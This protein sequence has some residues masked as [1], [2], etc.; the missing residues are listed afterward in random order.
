M[1]TRWVTRT[2]RG[3]VSGWY[4]TGQA[5]RTRDGQGRRVAGPDGRGEWSHELPDG[6]S[7]ERVELPD[8]SHE[9]ILAVSS[10]A[11]SC[12]SGCA[13]CLAGMHRMLLSMWPD[14][15]WGAAI[16]SVSH[17]YGDQAEYER[18]LPLTDADPDRWLQDPPTPRS[19]GE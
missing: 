8:L 16:R 19:H 11:A 2:P 7:V 1:P 5:A 13:H 12:D 3:E 14:V 17:V 9:L 6:W 15:D 18:D 10:L 4:A